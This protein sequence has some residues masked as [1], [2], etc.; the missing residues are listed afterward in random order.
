MIRTQLLAAALVAASL[1]CQAGAEVQGESFD[2]LASVMETHNK[3][4]DAR[5][6]L[7]AAKEEAIRYREAVITGWWEF[8]QARSNAAPGE[9]CVASFLRAKRR[10]EPGKVDKMK[11]GVVVTLFGPGGSYRGA[12]LAFSPLGDDSA[13]AFP[14][15]PS[16]T[17]V[18]VTLTQGNT[19]PVTLNA[20]YLETRP[21]A[22]PLLAFAVP[23]IDALM[24]GMEDTWSFDVSYQ[25]RSIANIEWHDG[26]KARAELQKC[27]AGAPF[28]NKRR[29]TQ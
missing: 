12:L 2:V 22:P 14:K 13:E 5:Q 25:G 8:M 3:E 24:K 20:I 10:V 28:D 17:P 11:E 29:R 23:S 18:R 1:S 6:T 15:L 4:I 21:K 16:G 26:L 27:L 19:K 7:D 9:Y